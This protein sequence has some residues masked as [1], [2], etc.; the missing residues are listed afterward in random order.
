MP[1]REPV[2]LSAHRC[3]TRDQV[4]RAIDLDVDFV[5]FDVQR[6]GDG[7]LVVF[8]DDVVEVDGHEVPLA[9][10][11]EAE[12]RA[13]VP[14]LLGYHDV[15]GLLGG[16][17]GAHLDLKFVDGCAEATA[18]AVEAFGTEDLVVTTLD[19]Q[20]V[21]DVR[22]WA[23][24]HGYDLKVG[25]SLGRKVTGFPV[26]RQV[27]VRASEVWPHLRYRQSRANV[28]VA[29]H[30]LARA[31]L[32]GFARRRRMPLLVWTV[33]TPGSLRYWMRPGRAWLVTTNHPEHALGI[34]ERRDQRRAQR[35]AAR[36][37]R[38]SRA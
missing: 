26:W 17:V 30:W 32:A 2:L 37:T 12:L 9:T 8:H 5:E 22:G 10:M 25:L 14:G 38:R 28:V 19:D 13:V 35:R 15:L 31:G 6:C 4:E 3:L 7:G 29:H 34:R 11:T 33:D 36:R 23:D 24:A 21:K 20:A 16:R 1:R 18:R 27:R